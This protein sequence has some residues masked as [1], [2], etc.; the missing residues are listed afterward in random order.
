MSS[1][2]TQRQTYKRT[3]PEV[4]ID[5]VPARHAGLK[6]RGS[7]LIIGERWCHVRIV[8]SALGLRTL[9]EKP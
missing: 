5:P 6:Q 7:S 8:H 2:E 9:F 3:P 1:F 4:E